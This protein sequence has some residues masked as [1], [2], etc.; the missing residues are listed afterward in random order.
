MKVVKQHSVL[1]TVILLVSIV[2]VSFQLSFIPT[3]LPTHVLGKFKGDL[4]YGGS[5]MISAN[6]TGIATIVETGKNAYSI[7]F[8][9]NVPSIENISFQLTSKGTYVATNVKGEVAGITI[10][11]TSLD[12]ALISGTKTWNFSGKK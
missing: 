2:S 8:N 1:Q 12:I 11:Q 3:K 7:E 5:K 6:G 9:K 4:S 10:S